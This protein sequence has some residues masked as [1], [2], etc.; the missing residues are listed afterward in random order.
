MDFTGDFF[1]SKSTQNS[2]RHYCH[3]SKAPLLSRSIPSL[4][5]AVICEGAR[6]LVLGNF[7]YPGFHGSR[8]SVFPCSVF[9]VSPDPFEVRSSGKATSKV[10]MTHP[11]AP[12]LE[13]CGGRR[14]SS[15]KLIGGRRVV[16]QSSVKLPISCSHGLS[17]HW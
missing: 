17:S 2:H 1:K 13:A 15:V 10:E 8:R 14:V 4:I 3:V 11:V 12:G 16:S 7:Q 6:P 9:L 5:L